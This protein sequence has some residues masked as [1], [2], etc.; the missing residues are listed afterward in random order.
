MKAIP[1]TLKEELARE[2]SQEQ[3]EEGY[4]RIEWIIRV[5][6]RGEQR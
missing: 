2:F 6:D 1:K 4:K 3:I 5:R